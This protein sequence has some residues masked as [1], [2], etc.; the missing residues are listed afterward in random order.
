[1][2]KTL[3]ASPEPKDQSPWDLVR[4][5]GDLGTTK[6]VQMMTLGWPWISFYGKVKFVSLYFDRG[7]YTFLQENF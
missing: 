7:K 4:N 6:F 2:V 1:M 5:I 3:Y